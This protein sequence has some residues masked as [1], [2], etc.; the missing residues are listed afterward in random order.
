MGRTNAAAEIHSP[1]YSPGTQT[2]VVMRHCGRFG[3]VS[4]TVVGL[5]VHRGFE[6]LPLRLRARDPGGFC[7]ADA[8]TCQ[9][10]P[11]HPQ[12]ASNFRRAGLLGTR[13]TFPAKR[14]HYGSGPVRLWRAAA[15][16]PPA[17]GTTCS[18]PAPRRG[19]SRRHAQRHAAARERTRHLSTVASCSVANWTS[20][21]HSVLSS[22]P[23]PST[24][25]A[26]EG[27]RL[28]PRSPREKAS[29]AWQT[30]QEGQ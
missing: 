15:P 28:V 10:S 29:H 6:S 18:P 8:G 23:G 21:T 22:P 25:I 1:L 7:N 17:I 11:E 24:V 12:I 13:Q 14:P 4:K 5:T 19:Q 27:S 26:A 16:D 3:A 30:R 2:P 9:N 20:L